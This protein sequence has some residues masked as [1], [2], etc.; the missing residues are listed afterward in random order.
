MD[1]DPFLRN[2]FWTI[3]IGSL[4]NSITYL[5]LNPSTT[6]RFVALPTYKMARNAL[7]FLML[8]SG[9]ITAMTGLIGMSIYAKYRDCDP[10]TANVSKFYCRVRQIITKKKDKP[11]VS[12][13]IINNI[14][15]ISVHRQ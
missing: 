8:G 4:I 10:S 3:S 11:D 14:T 12:I 1:P 2:S 15:I 7:I 5:G 13:N 6:Q 9:V